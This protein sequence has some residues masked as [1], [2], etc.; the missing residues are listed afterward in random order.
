[1]AI[2]QNNGNT[3]KQ[4]KCKCAVV[5]CSP[6][7][8]IEFNKKHSKNECFSAIRIVHTQNT[9]YIERNV[10]IHNKITR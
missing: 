5:N 9:H 6:W 1:M 7:N 3:T 8:D 4:A 2:I 10:Y